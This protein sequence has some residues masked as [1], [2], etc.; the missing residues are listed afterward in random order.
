MQ[1]CGSCYVVC[2]EGGGLKNE[3]GGGREEGRGGG[4]W[5]GGGGRVGGG[6]GGGGGGGEMTSIT[7]KDFNGSLYY[8][9]TSEMLIPYD[10]LRT[11]YI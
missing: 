11:L 6:G 1:K 2:V 8:F 5:G 3:E 9:G 10:H 4:G 7:R